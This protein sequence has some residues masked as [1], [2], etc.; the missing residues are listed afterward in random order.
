MLEREVTETMAGIWQITRTP[1]LQVTVEGN[2]V[3]FWWVPKETRI[4]LGYLTIPMFL[5][6]APVEIVAFIERELKRQ[7][8]DPRQWRNDFAAFKKN[9]FSSQ[10]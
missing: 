4:R 9:P 3:G 10:N 6:L 8:Y 2:N 1:G 7:G 5:T